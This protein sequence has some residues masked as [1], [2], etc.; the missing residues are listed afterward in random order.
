MNAPTTYGY[1]LTS[2]TLVR[3]PAVPLIASS[4][5]RRPPGPGD[6]CGDGARGS[7]AR[8]DGFAAAPRLARPGR[9]SSSATPPKATTASWASFAHD[10]FAWRGRA[11]ALAFPLSAEDVSCAVVTG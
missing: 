3:K 2:A 11:P 1:D 7:V 6:G 5:W 8:W 4:A 10:L 9:R